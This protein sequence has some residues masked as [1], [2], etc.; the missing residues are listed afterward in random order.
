[1]TNLNQGQQAA[2]EAFMQ[3]LFEDGKE[4]IISGA[5]GVGKTFLMKHFIDHVIPSYRDTCK[6]IGIEPEYDS[7]MMTATTN[8][9]AEVLSLTTGNP[10]ST[11]HSFLNLKVQEDYT[12][13]RTTLS[14][15]SAWTVHERKIIFIDEC[16][17]I[18]SNLYNYLLEGTHKCKLVFVGDHNQLAP[19]M[20]KISPI[21]NNNSPFFELT[22]PMR[23]TGQPALMALCAQLRETVQTGEFKPIQIVPGVIDHLNDEQ[24]AYHI[25]QV[26]KEQTFDNR[27][28]AYT[29]NRVMDFNNHIRNL[30]NLPDAYTDH[31]LLVNN[32]SIRIGRF[33]L[34][35]EE[36]VELLDVQPPKSEEI[37]PEVMFDYM[38]A[39]IKTR[40]GQLI[41]DV[42]IPYNITHY[43]D[44]I[45]YFAR[46]KNWNR[47][48]HMKQNF[49]DL[50]QRDAATTHKAQ[51]STYESVFIDL[52]DISTCRQPDQ[53][54]RLLYVACSRPR[55]RIFFYGKLADK[56]GGLIV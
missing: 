13:G 25:E 46:T 36:E 24:M 39:T 44:L 1:M 20:E 14:K 5:A 51:G 9:A 11:L 50:R 15:T 27:I 18:D 26:F 52:S 7:V 4:F 6:V 33:Q 48:F 30:R 32:Q 10:T 31:E 8:K 12:T 43:H 37:T 19:V 45:K 38:E 47:Y 29:N 55:S 23:N 21:Y 16:S 35:V 41:Y 42:K 54:A 40:L 28:L 17:M 22:E 34:S 49:P 53:A 2:T 3:F 56:Y